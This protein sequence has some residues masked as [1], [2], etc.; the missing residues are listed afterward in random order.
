MAQVGVP[1]HVILRGNDRQIF[2][3]SESDMAAYINWLKEYAEKYDVEIH[4]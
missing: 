3:G 4:A 1:Q 2:F